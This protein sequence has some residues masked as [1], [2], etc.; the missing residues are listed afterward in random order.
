MHTQPFMS[1]RIKYDKLVM[2]LIR[3]LVILTAVFISA[4][5]SIKKSPER[6]PTSASFAVEKELQYIQSEQIRQAGLQ[7]KIDTFSTH[8]RPAKNSAQNKNAM[9]LQDP[10][11][12]Q[13]KLELKES[14]TRTETAKN[15]LAIFL[16]STKTETQQL[17]TSLVFNANNPFQKIESLNIDKNLLKIIKSSQNNYTYVMDSIGHEKY[18]LAITSE[19]FTTNAKS[20]LE[21]KPRLDANISCNSDFSL[22]SKP[23]IKKLVKETEFRVHD[24]GKSG[25]KHFLTFPEVSAKNLDCTLT[26]SDG[27]SEPLKIH[28]ISNKDYLSS[29]LNIEKEACVLPTSRKLIDTSSFIHLSCLQNLENIE[30]LFDPEDGLNTR[31]KNLLGY[32]ISSK[33]I[34]KQD[35]NIKL[36]FSQAPKLDAIYISYLVF[37]NDFSG[38]LLLR[39]LEHHARNGTEIKIFNSSVIELKKDHIALL[40]FSQKYPNVKYHAFK[41]PGK[42]RNGV[43]DKFNALHRTNHIKAF[44]TL[45]E[46]NPELNTVIL[47]GRNIHD[48]F[49]FKTPVDH[50]KYPEMVNYVGGDESFVHWLDLDIEIKS[51]SFARAVARQVLSIWNSD[52]NSTL[53][54]PTNIQLTIE[55][56]TTDKP[57]SVKTSPVTLRHLY[58]SP[59]RDNYAL[60][61]FYVEMFNSAKDSIKIVSPYLR[62]TNNL[63]QAIMDALARN[64]KIEIYTRIDLKGDT[65][66]LILTDVNKAAINK[67]KDMISIYEWTEPGV[68]LHSKL[69]VIDNDLSFIG[70][71]NMNKRS[72]I[73][74]F[75]NGVLIH[76][77]KVNTDFKNIINI[78]KEGS[79]LV[80]EEQ[81]TK[82]WTGIIIFILDDKF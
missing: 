79:R 37:R 10:K 29:Q 66:A 43:G 1:S 53:F 14:Q 12:K 52:V 38:A 67:L 71:I 82:W 24:G 63:H 40:A 47:G 78:Y 60:E 6:L 57:E 34:Q 56:A 61:K 62:L 74:D 44:I 26:F 21:A 73:H 46:A 80:T 9:K 17:P 27:V 4:C 41:Y 58:S 20:K 18:A 23:E 16:Q 68:I 50:K 55:T 59:Y 8:I 33:E 51:P 76:S 54:Q 13:L 7:Y 36:D 69:I 42:I 75:E 35:P 48:G 81:S 5:T 65:A 2:K 11:Y 15:E 45:S 3:S 31:I 28:L 64:V 22:D 30:I 25:L 19:L 70:G 49:V 39:I 32:E 72:F 77:Q